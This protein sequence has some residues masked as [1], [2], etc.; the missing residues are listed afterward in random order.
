MSWIVVTERDQR[1]GEN[2]VVGKFDAARAVKVTG[3]RE[4]DGN[5]MADVHVG[6]NRGQILYRTASGRYVLETWSAWQNEETTY[7]FISADE[8]RDWLILDGEDDLVEQWFGEQE[9]TGPGRPEIGN[10]VKVS[11]GDLLPRVDAARRD[12]ESRSAAI[13]RL[14]ESAL[15]EIMEPAELPSF[16]SAADW[17]AGLTKAMTDRQIDAKSVINFG[18]ATG[19]LLGV[20]LDESHPAA[21]EQAGVI[22]GEAPDGGV[23][24]IGYDAERGCWAVH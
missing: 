5:N 13:R 15:P 17:A 7:R 11:L 10:E 12:G 18:Y 6:A 2:R 3:R 22:V 19:D 8:A 14:L 4:W 24:V 16:A 9:E 20:E 23:W 1:T 21:D